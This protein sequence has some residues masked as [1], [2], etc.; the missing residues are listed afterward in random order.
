MIRAL[1]VFVCCAFVASPAAGSSH[2]VIGSGG[3][4]SSAETSSAIMTFGQWYAGNA[5]SAQNRN[6]AGFWPGYVGSDLVPV[7][8]ALFQAQAE[9]GGVVLSWTVAGAAEDHAGFY[10]HRQSGDEPRVRLTRELLHGRTSYRYRDESPPPGVVSY[11]LEDVSRTGD[12]SWHGPVEVD[13]TQ[14]GAL[15]FALHQNLPNPFRGATRIAFQIPE[16]GPVALRVFDLSGRE[17]ARLV[18]AVLPPGAHEA[19]WD[20]HDRNGRAAAAGVYFYRLDTRR[21][22]SSR[23]LILIF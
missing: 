12:R 3:G 13:M 7:R 17:V 18:D 19:V 11:W 14:G 6:E 4:E 1:C 22:S 15:R 16:A 23:K 2:Q 21:A 5:V 9:D 20:G 10:V 8:L